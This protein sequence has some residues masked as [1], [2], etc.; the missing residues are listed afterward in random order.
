VSLGPNTL[1][2]NGSRFTV[3]TWAAYAPTGYGQETV[4]VPNVSPTMPPFMGS[5]GGT[6]APGGSVNGV[7][8]YGTASNNTL[9]TSIA[10]ANSHNWKVSPVWWAIVALIV[11]LVLLKSVHWRDTI[12]EGEES[13]RAGPVRERAE[14]EAGAS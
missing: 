5:G 6:A 12:L 10:N 3:P 11:G 8:G 13:G 9:T 1:A 4:G 7:G 2:E 14:A